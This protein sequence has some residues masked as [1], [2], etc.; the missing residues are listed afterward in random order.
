[1][2]RNAGLSVA[3]AKRKVIDAIGSGLS[4]ADAMKLVGRTVK[5]FENWQ[6]EDKD[7]AAKIAEVRS[8]RERALAGGKDE[9]VYQLGFAEWRKR[10]LGM[11]TYPHQQQWVDL[12]EGREPVIHHPSITY[13]PGNARRLLINTPPFHAKST[14]LTQHYVAYRICMNPEIRVVIVSKTQKQAAKYLYSVKRI[15]TER[16]FAELHAAYAPPGGFK[17]ERNEGSV[18]ARTMIYVAGRGDDAIDPAGK[19]PTVEAI[20]IGGQLQG[21]RA[22]LIIID[23]CE[24]PG[25]VGQWENHLDWINEV[26]Q[27]RLYSGKIVVVGTRVAP[28]DIFSALR[29]GSNFLSGKSPWTY[30]GQ[31]CVLE[32][33]EDP[34]DWVTLWPRSTVPLD[35]EDEE[36][37]EPDE[38]GLYP[39]WDGPALARIR[40]GI[41]PRSWA[42]LYMQQPIGDD[43]T[44]NPACVNGSVDRRRKPGPLRVGEWGGRREGAQGVH[45][46]LSIDPAGTGEAF[47][48]AYAVDRTPNPATGDMDRWVL[49]AWMGNHTTPDWYADQIEAIVPE[50]GVNEIVVESN[51]YANWI[52]H[53]KRIVNYCRNRGI[54]IMPHYTSHNK[55]DPDFGVAS[56]APLFGTVRRHVEG[57]REVFNRDNAI[58]LPDPDKSAGVK[59]LI[60]QLV[61]WQPGKLGKNLRMDGP[62]ALWFAELRARAMVTNASGQQHYLPSR[63]MARG[64]SRSRWIEPLHT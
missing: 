57:G 41:K 22:D 44:F 16:Q 7:F 4:R 14:V 50:Y 15:L 6:S 30:L 63:F 12:L 21:A 34:A 49:N 51:G 19:D 32:F 28:T 53:Y 25:N 42:L 11:E 64:R 13:E 24:D 17:P 37:I 38:N 5:T 1:M 36:K 52:I 58:H 54:P 59:A 3:D 39:T 61:S 46:V 10:F 47:M 8:Q 23:D 55:Q 48:L 33:A 26:V 56:M 43:A 29:D 62:M 27:S 18:W 31:P 60:E 40:E 45:T 35:V 2:P 20:G 9:T